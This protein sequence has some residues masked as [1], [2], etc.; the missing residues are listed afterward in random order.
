MP[1]HNS[2]TPISPLESLSLDLGDDQ[3]S[4]PSA[5]G[6]Q[7]SLTELVAKRFSRRN[8]VKAAVATGVGSGL[9]QMSGCA[10]SAS[11]TNLDTHTALKEGDDRFDFVEIEHGFGYDQL[12]A[13]DH[14]AKVL[15]KWGDPLFASAPKFDFYNQSAESQKQQFGFNCDY[16]GYL[17]LDPKR[18]ESARALL[19]VNH[20][21]PHPRFM[22]PN[23]DTGLEGL[24]K[25]LVEIEQAAMGNSI[26]E[27]FAV[28]GQWHV[29]KNSPFNRR[30]T[31]LDTVMRLSGPAAGN[32]RL[33]TSKDQSGTQVV[34]TVNNCAG[35]MTPW[36]TYLTC[37]ENFNYHFG[38]EL[39]KDH[40]ETN[41]YQR[42]NVPQNYMAWDKFDKRFDLGSE[43]NEPNRFGWMV[44]IDPLDPQST[45]VKRTAMG[46]FKHEGGENIIAEDGRLVVYMGDDQVFEYLYKF[47]SRDQVDLK[48]KS[49]NKDL[50]DH[51]TLYVAQFLQDGSLNWLELSTNNPLLANE[52][53]SQGDLLIETRRAA[54][55]VGATPMDRPEDVIPSP[56]TGKVYLMLTN[57]GE[58]TETNAANP[59]AENVFGHVIEI[60]ENENNA[61]ATLASWNIVVSCGDPNNAE[62]NAQWNSYTSENGWFASPD[63]AA[64][65]P[66]GRLWIAT[67]QSRKVEMSGTSDG[68]WSLETQGPRR[69][70][71]K[72]FYRVPRGAELTGPCF[73]QNGEAL[74]LA[75]QHPGDYDKTP[76]ERAQGGAI[77]WPEFELGQPPKPSVVVVTKRTG[78]RVG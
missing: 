1:S 48:K 76:A 57:N 75:V 21:Y 65:D 69:G 55:I 32:P 46:R 2:D 8:F 70:T 53:G 58:R 41:N 26:V 54:E 18:G 20:E 22:F 60:I 62:H 3:C 19:C 40:P 33:K 29:D 27:V 49:N 45:P 72:M 12:C 14:S 47:V 28:D 15:L 13:P 42:Y 9:S 35:G 63:N 11:Q 36:G 16:V 39:P 44:E 74:F 34:G 64:M 73:S 50:L 71:G 25:E 24:T 56:I 30:I 17:G 51:G 61:A 67:D 77:D 37:E 10:G 6:S 59:R 38:G 5:N 68:L 31:A 66:E 4:N 23:F 43:P 78:G 52:F 7:S